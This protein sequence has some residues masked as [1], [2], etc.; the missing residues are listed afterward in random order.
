MP[1]RPWGVTRMGPY[2]LTVKVPFTAVGIDPATQLGV[3]RDESGRMVNMDRTRQ[4]TS[5]STYTS[6]SAYTSTG[7]VDSSDSDDSGD[8]DSNSDLNSDEYSD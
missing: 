4:S 1:G 3:F 2:P 5:E 7:M 6:T 8:S